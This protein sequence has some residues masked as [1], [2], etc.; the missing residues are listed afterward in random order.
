MPRQL[1][2]IMQSILFYLTSLIS[3]RRE[4]SPS[5]TCLSSS[6]S[7]CKNVCAHTWLNKCECTQLPL[8]NDSH[9]ASNHSLHRL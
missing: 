9:L 5:N 2:C 4:Y 8:A 3:Y 7:L 1:V 6:A